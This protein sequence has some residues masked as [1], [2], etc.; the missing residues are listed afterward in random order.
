[1]I[2]VIVVF[3]VITGGG[4]SDGE[5]VGV[6]FGVIGG[7]VLIALVAFF[8]YRERHRFMSKTGERAPIV[9]D[10]QEATQ[11]DA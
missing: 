8:V 5:A 6:A 11:S 1:M 2:I 4:L 3:C 7:V 9:F 10:M